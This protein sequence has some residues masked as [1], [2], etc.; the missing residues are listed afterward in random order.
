MAQLFTTIL[1]QPLLNLLVF[2]YNIVPGNDIGLAIILLT[3]IIK[4]VLYPF[5][6]QSIKGQKALQQVQPKI[7]ELKRKYKDNKEAQGRE[8]MQLYKNEKVN[9]LS[10]CLPLLIQLPILLAVFQVFRQGLNSGS[11][12][13]LYPF[14]S[15]PG[16]LNPLSLGLVDLSK[17]NIIL[18]VLAGLAQFWQTK[19]LSVPRP[20]KGIPGAKDEDMMAIMNK[21]M[22]YFMPVMTVIIGIQLPGGLVLYWFVITLLTACQQLIMFRKDKNNQ[23]PDSIKQP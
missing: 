3:I 20:A 7:E 2:F 18:A 11:L 17:P 8:L 19:M 13:L 6:R 4:L 15:N 23:G 1:Y 16:Q 22:M 21:Q 14:I 10:S 12:E 9:P 5:S